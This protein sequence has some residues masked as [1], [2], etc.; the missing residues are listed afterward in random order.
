M[1]KYLA[2]I[3]FLTLL[4]SCGKDSGSDSGGGTSFAVQEQEAQGEYR[5][6]LRP[7]NYS[8]SGFFP[9]GFAE[10]KI[11]G[12][13][14]EVKTLLDDDARVS[15][16]QSIHTGTQCP[17]EAADRNGDGLVD[18][19]ESIAMSGPV[20][21][22]LDADINSEDAGEGVYPVGSGFTYI[23][24]ATLTN[25]QN[26]VKNRINQNLNLAG[27]VVMIHGV[28]QK[29]NIPSTMR[30]VD[31]MTPQASAPIACGVLYRVK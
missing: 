25:L 6:I 3:L 15:H 7:L 10:I 23:E 2:P 24:T 29:T 31:G 1:K 20:M 19:E 14:V 5:A 13:K 11:E 9:T 18:V 17:T 21:I 28:A 8:L 12:E 30:G 4:A 16:M 26:D 22:P 27:R